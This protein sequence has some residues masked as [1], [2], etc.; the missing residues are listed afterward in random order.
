MGDR[1]LA[2]L[3]DPERS[4][5]SVAAALDQAVD[6]QFRACGVIPLAHGP[7][8]PL[9]RLGTPSP[10]GAEQLALSPWSLRR[11]MGAEM[12]ATVHRPAKAESR[13]PVKGGVNI[14]PKAPHP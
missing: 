7:G 13:K 9:A 8:H 11:A 14:E 10:E 4:A 5:D 1:P 6:R 12:D 3:C 2:A